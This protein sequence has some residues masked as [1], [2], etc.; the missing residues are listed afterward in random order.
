M[1]GAGGDG[2]RAADGLTAGTVVVL[3]RAAELLGECVVKS[4]VDLGVRVLEVVEQRRVSR[5]TDPY[6][7][8]TIERR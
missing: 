2:R 4:R 6:L 3:V 7:H 1:L 8:L 5:R